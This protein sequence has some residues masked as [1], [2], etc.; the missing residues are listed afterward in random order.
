MFG[1]N[2]DTQDLKILKCVHDYKIMSKKLKIRAFAQFHQ[3]QYNC[4]K[5]I[6]S[7][8][9]ETCFKQCELELDN[10]FEEKQ[11]RKIG[12]KVFYALPIYNN[13]DPSKQYLI[14]QDQQG[15][16]QKKTI[17]FEIESQRKLNELKNILD[18][19]G[20]IYKL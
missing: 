6:N 8:T 13:S 3:C 20:K 11:K 9:V 4:V 18:E 17:Q 16:Y 2:V 1:Q 7:K 10:Y 19:R 5:D 14:P 15:E 12:N